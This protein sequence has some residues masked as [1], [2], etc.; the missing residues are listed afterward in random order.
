[1][2]VRGWT[3][4]ACSLVVGSA[5]G[6]AACSR[7]EPP[8]QY[9][10]Q[11]QILAVHPDKNQ[12]TIKHGD[13]DGLM[14]GMTMSFG[15]KTPALLDG[16]AAG[17]LVT[18]TLEVS[19]ALGTLTSITKTGSAPLPANTNEAALVAGILADGDEIPD[20]ALIDQLDRRRSLAEWR[21]TVTLYTFTYT[22]CPLPDFCPLMDQNF[23]TLQHALAEDPALRDA[24]RLVSISV[25]PEHDTP[26][27]LAAHAK[28][29]RADPAVWTFLT[30]DRQT[31]ERLA[32]RFGVGIVRAPDGSVDITHNL[33]TTL[34]GR[35]GR[36][37][38]IYTGNDWTPGA[39][40]ADLRVAVRA[41]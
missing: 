25:D 22:R 34:A 11:G 32:G 31:I 16:R 3:V 37:R 35:D 9:Q 28:K 15:V 6:V 23:A 24:V 7:A 36:V 13:I 14:P 4:W 20:A 18:A 17:D 19:D 2:R 41:E 40:L 27:V 33:R 1:M 30:G 5:L 21:G 29:R 8:K 38:K 10:L 12:I 26:A 39:V